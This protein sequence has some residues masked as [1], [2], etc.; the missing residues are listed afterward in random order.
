MYARRQASL[1]TCLLVVFYSIYI[2]NSAFSGWVDPD[3]PD[4]VKHIHSFSHPHED[5]TLVMSD[6]F[7]RDNREFGDGADPMWTAVDKADDDQT[8]SGKK[9][10]QFYNST[11]ITTKDGNLVIKTTTD[12]TKWKGWNPY[13]KKYEMMSRHFKSGKYIYVHI[14]TY[15]YM[16]TR[17][18]LNP[19]NYMHPSK[20]A[21]IH[22]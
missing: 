19:T 11:M 21:H 20:H 2:T 7:N 22:T 9:S 6:E 5:Y 4:H 18:L 13:E 17:F 1:T 15:I 3:S 14:Y 8:S 10:L 16:H 12:D